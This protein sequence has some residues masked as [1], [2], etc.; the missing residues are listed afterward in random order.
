MFKYVSPENLE[1][2]LSAILLKIADTKIDPEQLVIGDT[3]WSFGIP[4]SDWEEFDP[5]TALAKVDYPELLAVIENKP[6]YRE[7]DENTFGFN[8]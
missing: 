1:Q 3:F 7:I 8:I 4:G 2:I 5:I 6:V